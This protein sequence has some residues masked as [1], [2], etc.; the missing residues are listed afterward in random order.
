MANPAARG[1]SRQ[2]SNQTEHRTALSATGAA[3]P[4]LLAAL[5]CLIAALAGCG[6]TGGSPRMLDRTHDSA[7]FGEPRNYRIFLPAGY[8]SS[9]A[10]YPV[11]YY[12]HGHS[13]RYTLQHQDD[14][15]DTVPKIL[16]FVGSHDVIVVAVDGYVAEH[17]DG[18]YGGAPWDIARDG[19]QYDFGAYFLE[20]IRH[21]DQTWRTLPDRR[22]RATSGLSM[23]GFM[24]LY[25]S[26]RYPDLIG[27]A[28]AFNPGPEF[29]VGEPGRRLLWRPKDHVSNHNQTMVRL[30]RA[31]G[32][33]ISQYHELTRAAYARADEVDFEYRQ[34]DYYRHW[35]TSI[36]ETFDF[37]MRAFAR[38]SLDDVPEVFD[39]ADAYPRFDVWGYHVEAGG[40]ERGYTYLKGAR[41]GGMRITTRR[42]A[43]DGPPVTG[44]RLTITTAPLYRAG[45]AYR[46]LDYNLATGRTSETG[47]TANGDGRITFT[48]DGAGHQVSF[49]GPGTGRLPPVLLPVTPKDT[50][51]VWPARDVPLP[52]RIYNPARRTD[53]GRSG[54]PCRATIR[55]LRCSPRK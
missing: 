39:H 44:R 1:L 23:G 50:L 7:V 27:S 16:D 51:R 19:G 49:A 48:V 38:A 8:D 5:L 11:I 24:S 35:A 4:C 53:D 40:A 46:L 12:F 17:Y 42:W 28:S 21:I 25:L 22:H 30:I 9:G 45:A 55:P 13:D 15:K 29:Y 37:H 31:A 36:G 43:P 2:R 26:A 54:R 6:H 3:V 14:G 10:R 18:F 20:L 41:Q 33:Y 52:V 47:T 32:D 34:D